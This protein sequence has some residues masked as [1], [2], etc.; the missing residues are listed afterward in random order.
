M[1][2]RIFQFIVV[3]ILCCV[4]LHSQTWSALGSGVGTQPAEVMAL[5]VYNGELY[6]GGYFTLGTGGP[7]NY[8][9]KWNGTSWVSLNTG[10]MNDEVFSFAVYNG[11]L[12]A[13]GWFTVA[14][15][16]PASYIAKY[17]GT[18]W[19]AV[20][21]GMNNN[22]YVY[23]LG[24]FN[25]DLYAGGDFLNAGGTLANRIAKYNSG[26]GWSTLG[27]GLSN[28]ANATVRAFAIYN[29]Q[30][31]IGGSFSLTG[32]VTA[33]RVSLWNGTTFTGIGI[34][35]GTVYTLC[36]FNSN[37]FAGGIYSS[38]ASDIAQYNGTSWSSVGT[39][40]T[41]ANNVVFCLK[42]YSN[43]LYM[44]G[45]FNQV[46]NVWITYGTARYNPCTNVWTPLTTGT[47]DYVYSM[48][49]FNSDLIVG[50]QYNTAGSLSAKKVAKWTCSGATASFTE[51]TTVISQGMTVNYTDQSSG[52][53]TSWSWSFPGGTPSSS[54][55]QN[56]TVTYN[57]PGT[58]PVT[59]TVTNACGCSTSTSSGLIFVTSTLPVELTNF[60]GTCNSG[61][62]KFSWTT[63]S[64]TNND[65]FT[66]ERTTDGNNFELI[67]HMNGAGTSSQSHTY[68]VIDSSLFS[69]TAYYR[70]SQT[71]YNG[72]AVV[73]GMISVE[74]CAADFSDEIQS[75][76]ENNGIETVKLI[77]SEDGNGILSVYD[78]NGKLVL[79]EEKSVAKGL[80]E[81][82]IINQMAAGI[83]V[84]TF[85]S[86]STFLSKKFIVNN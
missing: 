43:Q 13:G 56:P 65:Y 46:D 57:T 10:G 81:E 15:G 11:E 71:N 41:G 75:V 35:N 22:G 60:Q 16:T 4:S 14:G 29:N 44:G 67:A 31:A 77:T 28:G 69:E 54:T 55:S 25:N 2:R 70:L 40:G 58:Y 26:S 38:P 5:A 18:T 39:N 23:A 64:E 59:L 33:N 20:G 83:Y 45:T 17:N 30:L 21:T 49:V 8:I 6:A 19:T 48:E 68:E 84:V 1:K 32:G 86:S 12:Y 36:T 51:N 80:N 9:A 62:I 74:S 34:M 42:E 27:S 24:V 52:S 73:A 72:S 82:K 7:G 78:A 53:A 63:A 61:K 37:L 76:Y 3:S 47:N 79:S 85:S 50:G 66:L